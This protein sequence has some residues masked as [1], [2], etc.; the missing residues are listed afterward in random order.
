MATPVSH[1]LRPSSESDDERGIILVVHGDR[2][3]QRIIHRILGATLYTI[4][5][6]DTA[7]QASKLLKQHVPALIVLDHA[8]LT[9][10]AGQALVADASAAGTT[11]CLVLVGDSHTEDIPRLFATGSLTNLLAHPMPVLAEELPVTALK[12]LRN[13]LFGLEKYMAWGVEARTCELHN[14]LDRT[15]AVDLLARDVR[16]FGLGPRVASM[17]TLIA[18]ELL[19]NAL[20][21]APVDAD[22]NR[23]RISEPRH[24][25]RPLQDRDQVTLRYACDA[26]YL[27]IEVNDHYG[28]L[29][30]E[31]ILSHL[32]KAPRRSELDKVDFS[33]S[34]AGM[35][36]ALSYSCCNHLVFNLDPGHRTEAI[37]LIDVRFKPSELRHAVPSFNVFQR[38]DR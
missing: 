36:I 24:T 18:D 34:G 20:Y 26:R 32:A 17:A 27:A 15:D 30:R 1:D 9:E 5:A 33:G 22:G 21:D 19:S 12:L 38:R 6:V 23:L 11:G 10:P 7:A 25:D 35:G 8:I 2:K 3:T 14:A 16:E 37:G 4:D 31:T 13:D 29:D 28:S